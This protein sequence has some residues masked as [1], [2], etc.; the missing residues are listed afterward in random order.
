[1]VFFQQIQPVASYIRRRENKFPLPFPVTQVFQQRE[2][3][4]IWVTRDDSNMAN[5]G[6]DSVASFFRR[7]DRSIR[8]VITY[9]NDRVIPVTASE[10]MAAEF[11]WYEA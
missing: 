2:G 3:W 1:M 4:P 7:D 5:D 6:E 8:E 10:E 9:P 11:G